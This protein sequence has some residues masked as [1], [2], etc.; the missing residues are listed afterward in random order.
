MFEGEV[1]N[2]RC[3]KGAVASLSRSPF[4]TLTHAA[5]I[6]GEPT[7]A[8]VGQPLRFFFVSEVSGQRGRVAFAL[9]AWEQSERALCKFIRHDCRKANAT[10]CNE[11]CGRNG[12]PKP[13]SVSLQGFRRACE[14][15]CSHRSPRCVCTRR[16]WREELDG[17]TA[18]AAMGNSNFCTDA[19]ADLALLCV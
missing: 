19:T 6:T 10:S 1:Y 8:E 9:R 3:D 4:G 16:S 18:N 15:E 2:R 7:S 17:R 12:R 11:A 13:S 14:M 5:K